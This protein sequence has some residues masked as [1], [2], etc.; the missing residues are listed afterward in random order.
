MVNWLMS[1]KLAKNQDFAPVALFAEI[2][3]V[4]KLVV[5]FVP[6]VWKNGYEVA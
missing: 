4:R 1:P 2:A 6:P 3:L 5:S